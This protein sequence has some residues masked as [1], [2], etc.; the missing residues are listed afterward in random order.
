MEL[1]LSVNEHTRLFSGRHPEL[2]TELPSYRLLSSLVQIQVY[3]YLS[4]SRVFDSDQ[5]LK[6]RQ[7]HIMCMDRED[8]P[9]GGESLMSFGSSREDEM[10]LEEYDQRKACRLMCSGQLRRF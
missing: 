7:K 1:T 6:G 5:I 4:D 9:R 3:R 8:M 10:V 2:S